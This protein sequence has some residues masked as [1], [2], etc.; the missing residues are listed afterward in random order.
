MFKDRFR[1]ARIYRG[2]TLQE[3]ADN[4]GMALRSIQK[5]E[6]GNREPDFSTLVEIADLFDVPTD[7]L[8]ERDD[9]LRSLGV[10]VD[11]PLTNPPRRPNGERNR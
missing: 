9:Y 10:S 4:L 8:L 3:V 1:S 5:Y 6:G 2:Y 7:F 11:V